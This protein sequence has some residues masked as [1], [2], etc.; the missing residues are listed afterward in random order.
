MVNGRGG[1]VADFVEAITASAVVVIVFAGAAVYR[2]VLS[3][4][5][6]RQHASDLS[7]RDVVV[8]LQSRTHKDV[9]R[10]R[11][12]TLSCS[13]LSTSQCLIRWRSLYLCH[14]PVYR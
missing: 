2:D 13:R 7:R 14:S 11:C 3:S 9:I 10:L 6:F 12:S 5:H 1:A 8:H 4:L